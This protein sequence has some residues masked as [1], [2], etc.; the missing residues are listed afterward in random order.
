MI[1]TWMNFFS[2]CA[3]ALTG[4]VLVVSA[5]RIYL[6]IK[7]T[8]RRLAKTVDEKNAIAADLRAARKEEE[9]TKIAIEEAESHITLMTKV[10]AQVEAQVEHLKSQP[11]R[12][13]NMVDNEWKRFDRL[14]QVAVMNPSMP[15]ALSR[16]PGA[17]EP[18]QGRLVYGFARVA[19]EFRNR[20]AQRYSPSAGFVL[21]DAEMVDLLASTAPAQAAAG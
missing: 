15:N 16:G 9:Q 13:V 14:W 19:D 5:R 20:V 11:R 8:E 3:L 1:V 6:V 4:A 7:A 2:L 10:V 12:T 17:G 21:S 18:G